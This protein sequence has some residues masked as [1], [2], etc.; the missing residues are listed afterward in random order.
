MKEYK[1]F[2]FEEDVDEYIV[3]ITSTE[4]LYFLEDDI[5]EE[6]KEKCGTKVYMLIIHSIGTKFSIIIDL[7]LRNGFSFNRFVLL[8]YNGRDNKKSYIINPREISE[9]IKDRVRSY[10]IDN[11]ELL[12]NSALPKYTIEFMKKNM[13]I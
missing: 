2:K 1:I 4:D 12:T 6:M 11:E 8:N 9:K 10:L 3:L 13:Y 5:Y 7:F